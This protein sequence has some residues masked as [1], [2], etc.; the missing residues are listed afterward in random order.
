MVEIPPIRNGDDLGMVYGIGFT[1]IN[2]HMYIYMVIIVY[3]SYI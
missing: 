1:N 3:Y 2:N